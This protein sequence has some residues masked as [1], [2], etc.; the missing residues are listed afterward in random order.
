MT[1]LQA[2][3]L[4]LAAMLAGVLNSVAGGGSFVSFPALIFTGV[5]AINANAT[6]TVAVWPGTVASAS[7]Y[8]DALRWHRG[9]L[10]L[11]MA[12]LIG[13]VLGAVLLLRTPPATFVRLIPY[14]LLVATLLFTFGSSITARFRGHVAKTANLSWL[15]IVGLAIFQLAVATYGGYFGGG[16]GILMLAA[17]SLMGMENIHEMNALKTVLASCINGVAV[18]TFIFAGTVFWGQAAV[19]VIGAI[20]GGYGGASFARRLDPLVVRRFVIVVGIAMTAYF[21]LRGG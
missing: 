11:V 20:A 1:L 8:R 13:G 3:T 5:P 10:V 9:V 18:L 7:A 15:A 21:F 6:N 16:I 19:M 14:L 17:L 2:V 4:F 12:S